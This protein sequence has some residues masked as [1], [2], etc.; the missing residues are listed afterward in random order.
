M[1][2]PWNTYGIPMEYLWNTYGIPMEYLWNTYGI[3]MEYLWNT[4]GPL[5]SIS[6][7]QLGYNS[8]YN[9]VFLPLR[10]LLNNPQK[11]VEHGGTAPHLV[12]A[13]PAV[14]SPRFR[15]FSAMARTVAAHDEA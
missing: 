3:P 11:L 12:E 14:S 15:A 4:Y 9:P 2:Y 10:L 1:E 8:V 13:P 5:T 7:H 6:D